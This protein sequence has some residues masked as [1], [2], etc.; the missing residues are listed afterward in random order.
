MQHLAL[1]LGVLL[2]SAVAALWVR[3]PPWSWK[4]ILGG[5]AALVAVGWAVPGVG[6]VLNGKEG[7]AEAL[8]EGVLLAWCVG[9]VR[10]RLPIA[11]VIGAVLLLEEVDY[12]QLFL[13]FPTPELV[14]RLS[15]TSDAMNF[16][17][18]PWLDWI[19]RPGAFGLVWALSVPRVREHR[20]LRRPVAWG[21]PTFRTLHCFFGYVLVLGMGTALLLGGAVV[22]ELH[23]AAMVCGAF[24]L[25][26]QRPEPWGPRVTPRSA[27]RAP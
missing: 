24:A 27:P 5:Y 2:A 14:D 7:V 26:Q 13:R 10:A 22:D 15:A 4:A 11:A 18:A 6:E 19:W 1:H 8:T 17:N 16:H 12:G 23:E 25:W 21:L 20:W 3:W 9:A